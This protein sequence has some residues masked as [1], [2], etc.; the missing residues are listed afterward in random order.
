MRPAVAAATQQTR[1][2]SI[3]NV[4]DGM[5]K[6]YQRTYL[7]AKEISKILEM[8]GE[9][10]KNGGHVYWLGEGSAGIWGFVDA[11]EMPD[12]YGAAFTEFRGFC[13]NGW[14]GIQT[15]EGDLSGRGS[16]YRISLK[17]FGDDI[18]PNLT[19]S[20]TVIGLYV[21]AGDCQRPNCAIEDMLIKIATEK[22]TVRTARV[23]C[24]PA[25]KQ[26][27]HAVDM[28]CLPS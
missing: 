9:S 17:Q 8:C 12:T 15:V 18:F 24:G 21:H 11:S 13:D 1:K 26:N 4:L 28:D 14:Y 22:Q 23:I 7:V 2:L 5:E 3:A 6:A 25:Q 27:A 10:I 19:A 16:L 20:D